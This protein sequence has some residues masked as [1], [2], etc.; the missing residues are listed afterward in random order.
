[1]SEVTH[2]AAMEWLESMKYEYEPE[3]S[4]IHTINYI[5]EVLWRDWDMRN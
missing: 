3:D 5:Q 2:E 4:I 1:M